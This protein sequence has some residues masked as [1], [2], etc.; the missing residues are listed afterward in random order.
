ME[1]SVNEKVATEVAAAAAFSGLK[2]FAAM[3]NA[4]V[5]VALDFLLHLNLTGIGDNSGALV[6]VMCDDP[7]AW[8]SGDEAD[9]R[10]VSQI[11]DV[12]LLEPGDVQEAKDMTRW[13]FDLSQEFKCYCLLRSYKNLSH[14]ASVI[15]IGEIPT[16]RKRARFDTSKLYSP[17]PPIPKHAALHEMH[18][19]IREVFESSPFNS[20]SGPEQP[21][22][23][24]V[25][26]GSGRLCSQDAIQCLDLTESVGI[27]QLAT[28]WPFPKRLV[29]RYLARTSRVLVIEEVDPFIE[30]HTKATA[31][32]SSA[33]QR[34]LE[35]YG[36]A[37]GHMNYY[38]E[39]T[40][41]AVIKA[42]CEIF[43]L[44][45]HSR[46]PEYEQMASRVTVIDRDPVWCPG[47]PHRASYV[48]LG[49]ATRLDGR[50]A[51]ITGD[52]GCYVL[53][54]FPHGTNLTNVLHCM[55]S[56]TGTAC[57]FGELEQLGLTQPVVAVCGDSTFYHAALPALLNA[58][59][60]K[61][62]MTLVVLDNGSTA[63]TG[64]QP[65]P[66][67]GH[68]ATGDETVRL[69]PEKIAKAC[70]VGFVKTV[71]PFD[72][73]NAT[74]AIRQAIAFD[75]PAVVVSRRMCAL[76]AQREKTRL[77][78]KI[79]PCQ[80]EQSKCS[81]SALDTKE[82]LM[83]C[84]VACPVG[85]DIP[86]FLN[87]VER[88]KFDEAFELVKQS[89]PL[90]AVLGRVCYHPCESEC[91]RR[92]LDGALANHK[93][94]R[95]LGDYGLRL[96]SP[97]R[98]AATSEEKVAVIG[99][100]PAGLSCAYHLAMAGYPVTVFEA[101]P[102]AGGMLAVGIPDYRLPKD[103]LKVEIG[104]IEDLGVEIRLNTT[105]T[106]VSQLLKQ[107]Y[108]AVFVSAG[109]HRDMKLDVPG[110]DTDGVLSAMSF[111]REINLSKP[112]NVGDRVIVVGGGNVAIDS[113]RVAVR[114]GTRQVSIVYRRSR[115]EM[116]ASDEEVEAAVEEG[117]EIC[118]LAAPIRILG[119]GKVTGLEC[120]RVRLGE[121]DAS[122][123][124]RPVPIEG[125][126]HVID[127]DTIIMAVGQ[128]PDLSFADRE[129][130]SSSRDTLIV[131]PDT[132]A[133]SMPGVFAGGDVVTGPATAADAV[134]AGKRAAISI[135]RYLRGK[136]LDIE[137]KEL[138]VVSFDEL[139]TAHVPP[140]PRAIASVLPAASRVKGFAE[141]EGGFAPDTAMAEA[142]RC[143]SCGS[144][145]ERCI[146]LLHCPA[147][148]RD[149]DGSTMIDGFL[150]N[151]CG[152][153]A[154]IC[155]CG[156]ITKME[157]M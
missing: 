120:T 102:V 56:G 153:C 124:A 46:E 66:G 31:F 53:D 131:E 108:E 145:S 92:Q 30:L 116:P 132:L 65:N 37:S 96:H 24:I 54:S 27:L 115:D 93:I 21:E 114:L 138:P 133:T 23:L 105:I 101:L 51:I 45:Y 90:P 94:E 61:S 38:G 7:Q 42:L 12:P 73:K 44:E 68:I 9:T 126:K 156:A 72:L 125:T 25:C 28:L 119:D 58:V 121:P 47:C 35:I 142:Q 80:I 49:N 74:A 109:A 151:G 141:V 107:G 13:A 157:E 20:Y 155:P 122:G 59:H 98:T 62:N 22:L 77:G 8:S 50:D 88:G 100:G 135:D 4:G 84:A 36:K 130:Q 5:N 134:G 15:K 128:V 129:L 154:D 17:Y 19:R 55:G 118:Y 48:C 43:K 76:I 29:E 86:G 81:K 137:E 143:L 89:N 71:D 139:N 16:S 83:P 79:V 6:V 99:S 127:A 146:T 85:N 113:A 57:G 69:E 3:K 136:P 117:I 60:N 64:F 70:S 32:E 67:T 87:L 97:K 2:A 14:S 147:I 75:G 11:A 104:K 33:V 52:I 78:E 148:I 111:L 144:F 150:C 1:W 34:Q 95:F 40:P 123:R 91:N 106:S 152:V 39:T 140:A 26:S 10:W 41:D 103:V 110:E 63:M 18:T 82:K 112:A 149:S